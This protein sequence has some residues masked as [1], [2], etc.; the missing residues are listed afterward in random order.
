MKA[1]G[2]DG[3]VPAKQDVHRTSANV[4]NQLCALSVGL[5]T[6]VQLLEDTIPVRLFTEKK[7]EI[8][9]AVIVDRQPL[10]PVHFLLPVME[11]RY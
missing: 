6:V 11:V 8:N 2:V 10:H 1:E 7:H 3:A 4:R 9:L 5:A